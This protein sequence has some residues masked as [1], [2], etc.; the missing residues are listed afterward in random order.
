L[1]PPSNSPSHASAW[2]TTTSNPIFYHQNWCFPSD[3]PPLFSI[4]APDKLSFQTLRENRGIRLLLH[5]PWSS[6][7]AAGYPR[8]CQ[9]PPTSKWLAPWLE[10]ISSPACGVSS[11]LASAS[12]L[13]LA[14]TQWPG[15]AH[16]VT[17]LLC[18]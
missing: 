4:L 5:T 6:S 10:S 7:P 14:P 16:H 13:Q 8:A 15:W 18:S 12:A 11:C 2:N 17:C 9:L 3:C 1:L